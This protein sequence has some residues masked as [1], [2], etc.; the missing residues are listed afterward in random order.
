[1]GMHLRKKIPIC[2]VK[3]ITGPNQ[4][5]SNVQKQ[6]HP[7]LRNPRTGTTTSPNW[8]MTTDI[9][10]RLFGGAPGSL[11]ADRLWVGGLKV[12][13]TLSATMTRLQLPE[14]NQRTYSVPDQLRS[15][16]QKA[17]LKSDVIMHDHN[18]ISLV[19][20]CFFFCYSWDLS[21]GKKLNG[22]KSNKKFMSSLSLIS[23]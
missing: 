14:G 7:G 8:M 10:L 11:V 18:R 9:M 2:L 1:M 13:L 4:R 3:M 22:S 20:E 12:V 23:N 19:F 17:L 21:V 5:M 6:L 15:Q 16:E